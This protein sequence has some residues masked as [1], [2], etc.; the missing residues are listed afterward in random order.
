MSLNRLVL[1]VC[2]RSFGLFLPSAP[3]LCLPTL[4]S[5]PGH[6]S[7]KV[8]SPPRSP[9][10]ARLSLGWSPAPLT[11]AQDGGAGP[12]GGSVGITALQTGSWALGGGGGAERESGLVLKCPGDFSPFVLE[13]SLV[14]IG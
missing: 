3:R 14:W 12:P 13:I 10:P 11:G 5:R 9:S 2:A 4:S 6:L 8:T 7:W 1:P